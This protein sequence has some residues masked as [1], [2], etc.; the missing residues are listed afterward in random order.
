MEKSQPIVIVAENVS[1]VPS[2]I[3][4]LFDA[5]K[6]VGGGDYTRTG[7]TEILTEKFHNES[8]VEVKQTTEYGG[9]PYIEFD[10]GD[11]GE[12]FVVGKEVVIKVNGQP[13]RGIVQEFDDGV[14]GTIKG[15]G[16]PYLFNGSLYP[17][18]G[19]DYFAFYESGAV[20]GNYISGHINDGASTF[21][22]TLNGSSRSADVDSNGDWIYEIPEGE[23]ITSLEESFINKENITSLNFSHFDFSNVTSMRNA[24]AYCHNLTS[25]YFGSGANTINI[26]DFG[27][28]FH[29]CTLLSAIDVENIKT[30]G[31]QTIIG[32]FQ[33]CTNLTSL[34]LHS[35]NTENL[36]NT[37]GFLLGCSSL[38]DV[39][40]ENWETSLVVNFGQMFEDCPLITYLDLSSFNTLNANISTAMFY[41]HNANL[42]VDYKASLWK[43]SII[44]NNQDITWNN[45]E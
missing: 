23:T 4:E 18:N 20:I 40:F 41:N 11:D 13:K 33:R 12:S 34:D 2:G 6:V 32:M 29:E 3:V 27:T 37:H 16:N 22:F 44:T 1:S 25:F 43:Q 45:V 28:A 35:W 9:N 38:T 30:D 8:S 19:L 39:N 21:T 24:C 17:D 5:K 26:E 14:G 10:I 36:R 42:V 31:A 7:K 15:F